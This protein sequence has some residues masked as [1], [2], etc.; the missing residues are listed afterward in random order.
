MRNNNEMKKLQLIVLAV[1]VLVAGPAFATDVIGESQRYGT[2]LAPSDLIA[3]VLEQ[4]GIDLEAIGPKDAKAARKAFGT[5][6]GKETYGVKNATLVDRLVYQ[7]LGYD[8]KLW[9]E[10]KR[11]HPPKNDSGTNQEEYAHGE[12]YGQK[13]RSTRSWVDPGRDRTPGSPADAGRGDGSR[14]GRV[15]RTAR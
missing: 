12:R 3:E 8:R 5:W 4:G 6:M 7:V 2:Q 14:S 10:M 13:D 9:T 11:A 15:S 1:A